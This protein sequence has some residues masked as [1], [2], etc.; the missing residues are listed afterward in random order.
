MAN[1]NLDVVRIEGEVQWKIY[2]LVHSRPGTG[3]HATGC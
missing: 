3:A 2:T 1:Q